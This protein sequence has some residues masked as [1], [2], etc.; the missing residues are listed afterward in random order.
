MTTQHQHTIT[1]NHHHKNPMDASSFIV[2]GQPLPQYH[3]TSSNGHLTQQQP[4]QRASSADS[5]P[6]NNT[7][8]RSINE[9]EL[10]LTNQNGSVSRNG[11]GVA[12]MPRS[13]SSDHVAAHFHSRIPM[14]TTSL[15]P[16]MTT[17]S[18][19]NG[20]GAGNPQYNSSSLSSLG[21]VSDDLG[22]LE[23]PPLMQLAPN[24]THFYPSRS[25]NS[26]ATYNGYSSG[27]SSSGS[28]NDV[29]NY[30]DTINGG[31]VFLQNMSTRNAAT[32]GSSQL[33]PTSLGLVGT[34][35]TTTTSAGG[36]GGS[37]VGVVAP[38]SSRS[39]LQQQAWFLCPN[40]KKTFTY[41]NQDSFDP[42]FEHIKFCNA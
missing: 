15:S 2:T 23:A 11:S 9:S 42:W 20:N 21:Y 24:A 22:S 39:A 27:S 5:S 31:R 25:K 3:M 40:C 14:S 18:Y 12:I 26:L 37:R 6:T 38:P 1:T 28:G 17:A 10:V 35:T 29:S 36:P 13:H 19:S 34:T 41:S 30:A 4:H 16:R 7:K 32:Q 8:L 33:R